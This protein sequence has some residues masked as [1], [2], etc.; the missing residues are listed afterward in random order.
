MAYTADAD[1]WAM[2]TAARAEL[3]TSVRERGAQDLAAVGA[4]A[5]EIA[6]TRARLDPAAL[7]EVAPPPRGLAR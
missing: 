7:T 6:A 2:R 5:G 1:L 4:C 3:V